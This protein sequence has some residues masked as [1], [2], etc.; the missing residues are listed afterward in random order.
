MR[1]DSSLP[2]PRPGVRHSEVEEPEQ[3]EDADYPTVVA[4]FIAISR[5]QGVEFSKE[6]LDQ[7]QGKQVPGRVPF[8]RQ[9]PSKTVSWDNDGNLDS[10]DFGRDR[11]PSG[12]ISQVRSERWSRS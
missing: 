10:S 5:A 1:Q 11:V 6:T 4:E 2:L 9:A 3:D 8:V 12:L 7:L